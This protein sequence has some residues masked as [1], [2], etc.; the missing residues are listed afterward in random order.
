MGCRRCFAANRLE[1]LVD[2]DE[3]RSSSRV[4]EHGSFLACFTTACGNPD[5][6]ESMSISQRCVNK[7]MGCPLTSLPVLV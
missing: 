7:P 3:S 2:E 6:L 1:V 5:T 4:R